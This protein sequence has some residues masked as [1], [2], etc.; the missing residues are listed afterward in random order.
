MPLTKAKPTTKRGNHTFSYQN[1]GR[2]DV[3]SFCETF[4]LKQDTLSRMTGYSL[5]AVADWRAGKE[6]SQSS[7]QRLKEVGR[8]CAALSKVVKPERVG[9]WLQTPNDA[10]DGSTP[11]QVIERGE[12]DRLWR[13]IYRLESGEPG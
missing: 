5:R 9:Q 13:M 2:F 7:A 10:F 3:G 12:V 1:S 6:L 11:L 4:H 8:L